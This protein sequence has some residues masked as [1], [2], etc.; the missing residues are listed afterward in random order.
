YKKDSLKPSTYHSYD[1]LIRLH[2]NPRIG[3]QKVKDLKSSHIQKLI[4]ECYRE[5]RIKKKIKNK[6]EG[7]NKQ[8]KPAKNP[9]PKGLSARTVKY[10]HGILLQAL[11]QAI[12]ERLIAYNPASADSINLPRH[13][14]PDIQPLYTEQA[15]EFLQAIKDNSLYPL[16][17]MDISTGLRRGELLG[18]K[19]QDIN[20][21][22][23]TATIKRS[24]IQVGGKV[25]LQESVKTKKS[26]RIV[27]L[28][29]DV[30]AELKRLKARQAQDK[31]RIGQ[32]YQNNSYVFCWEDGRPLRPDY[33]YHHFVDLLEELKLPKSRFHD[34]RHSF[35]TIMLEQGVDLETVSTM[36]GHNSLAITADIYTHVRQ[37]IQAAA[38]NKINAALSASK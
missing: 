1:Q 18:L 15:R 12:K 7:K 16:Y 33:V 37:E 10:I 38:A 31:L 6:K 8:D 27:S 4:N 13:E 22:D 30:M 11:D 23:K 32:A 19:W 34:L 3:D 14:K 5:G 9:K 35:A 25:V 20:F 2:I 24:L 21:T 29:D 17:L 28:T 26:K 36:L